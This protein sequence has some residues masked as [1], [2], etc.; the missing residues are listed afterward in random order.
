CICE[1]PTSS[2][3][4]TTVPR[5]CRPIDHHVTADVARQDDVAGGGWVASGALPLASLIPRRH[6]EVGGTE[7]GS[8]RPARAAAPAT[9]PR[10]P[11]ARPSP[12]YLRW[13]S[14]RTTAASLSEGFI[15]VR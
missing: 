13:S 15:T 3:H 6:Q 12:S 8:M 2:S 4:A 7:G 11:R 10:S 14:V 5:N 9:A 1:R